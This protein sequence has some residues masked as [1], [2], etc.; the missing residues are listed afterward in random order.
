MFFYRQPQPQL[1]VQLTATPSTTIESPID[2]F[3][4]DSQFF[5]IQALN[6]PEGEGFTATVSVFGGPS[7]DVFIDNETL[8]FFGDPLTA[9]F[10]VTYNGVFDQPYTLIVSGSGA[11]LEIYINGR[12]GGI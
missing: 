4:G 6:V 1:P 12:D 2:I 9:G 7:P 11:Q 3:S 8:L 5:S 10:T